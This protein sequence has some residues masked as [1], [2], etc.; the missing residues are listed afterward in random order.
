MAAFDQLAKLYIK[1]RQGNATFNDI[2]DAENIITMGCMDNDL[3]FL[4]TRKELFKPKYLKERLK[5][6]RYL[7]VEEMVK[8]KNEN[9]K[10]NNDSDYIRYHSTYLCWKIDGDKRLKEIEE[11]PIN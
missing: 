2:N 6:K 8:L 5:F 4:Y 9:S 11:R 3:L 10:W 1:M 7:T